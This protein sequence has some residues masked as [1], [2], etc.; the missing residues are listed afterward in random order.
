MRG[1]LFFWAWRKQFPPGGKEARNIFIPKSEKTYQQSPSSFKPIFLISG[2]NQNFEYLYKG[3]L[4]GGQLSRSQS[5]FRKERSAV[6]A[7]QYVRGIIKRICYRSL[8]PHRGEGQ[9]EHPR[10]GNHDI[11][12]RLIGEKKIHVERELVMNQTRDLAGIE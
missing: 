7:V 11:N 8:R 10:R 9:A 2:L 1:R 12:K 5:G 6:D 4:K 3:R